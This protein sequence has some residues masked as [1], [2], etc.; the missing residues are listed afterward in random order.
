VLQRHPTTGLYEFW[1]P[2]SG[3]RPAVKNAATGE[4]D[5][6]EESA[7]VFVLLPGG[8]ASLGSPESEPDREP[9][10]ALRTETF[11]PFFASKYEVTQAQW[12]RI[13]KAN[14]SK[15]QRDLLHPVENVS[16]LDCDEFATRLALSLPTEEQ[17][18][19][20]CRAG[21]TTP[22]WLGDN[23]GA[24][25][26]ENTFDQS[27]SS[28]GIDT[29]NPWDDGEVAHARV[30]FSP[31]NRFGLFDVHGNVAEWCSDEPSS[32]RSLPDP[33]PQRNF[34]GGSYAQ[35]ARYCRSAFRQWGSPRTLNQAL[36]LR[37]VRAVDP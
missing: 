32:A 18:E 3:E 22:W 23:S 12:A 19:Y 21:S 16:A 37:V 1:Y 28:S 8:S 30:G 25:A 15:F 4:L 35:L 9:N 6:R 17:W 5:Y 36:G 31:P 20:A 24:L 33:I 11:A 27:A 26:Q 7:I 13:M 2:L 10:E 29:P 14:P 34:R